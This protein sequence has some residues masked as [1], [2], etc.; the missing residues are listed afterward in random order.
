ME[1]RR[2]DDASGNGGVTVS[3]EALESPRAAPKA[4]GGRTPGV[5]QVRVGSGGLGA[6][7]GAWVL[8]LVALY[9]DPAEKQRRARTRPR[10]VTPGSMLS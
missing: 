3:E 1:A 4:A 2:V 5:S 7:S 9:G 10:D 6:H 8:E